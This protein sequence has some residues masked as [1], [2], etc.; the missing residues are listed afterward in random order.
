[1]SNE[2][3]SLRRFRSGIKNILL[4]PFEVSTLRAILL[5]HN[6]FAITIQRLQQ[7]VVIHA[8]YRIDKMEIYQFHWKCLS[9][10]NFQV[11]SIRS[12]CQVLFT[13]ALNYLLASLIIEMDT[14]IIVFTIYK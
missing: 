13:E 14:T 2:T 12:I 3:V 8:K 7:S 1:M 10:V 6:S 9:N 5:Q 4:F 11:R